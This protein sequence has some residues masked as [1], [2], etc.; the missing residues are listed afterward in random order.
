MVSLTKHRW[1]LAALLAS[2]AALVLAVAV[3]AMATNGATSTAVNYE[4]N[5]QALVSTM[6]P[7]ATSDTSFTKID[8]LSDVPI[9]SVG[10]SSVTFNGVFQGAPVE[11]RAQRDGQRL[12]PGP[13]SFDPGAGANAFSFT[14]VAVHGR[15]DCRHYGIAWRSPSGVPVEFDGGSFVVTYKGVRPPGGVICE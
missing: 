10:P 13:V 3:V 11:L 12:N 9:A 14:F 7:A 2:L 1:R 15:R 4:P 6:V 8:S 5:R